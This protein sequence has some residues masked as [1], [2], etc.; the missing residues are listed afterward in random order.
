MTP[1]EMDI[2]TPSLRHLTL[3]PKH[4]RKNIHAKNILNEISE[5]AKP[6]GQTLAGKLSN[7][8]PIVTPK[9]SRK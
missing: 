3:K 7:K 5:K 6:E 2:H 8:T 1:F 4:Q 9:R